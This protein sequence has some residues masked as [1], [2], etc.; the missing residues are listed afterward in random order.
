MGLNPRVLY[1]T[2][3]HLEGR[4]QV[5]GRTPIACRNWSSTTKH[6]PV[7]LTSISNVSSVRQPEGVFR[8]S[9]R[10]LCHSCA[11]AELSGS[12]AFP[13]LSGPC[14]PRRLLIVSPLVDAQGNRG[15]QRHTAVCTLLRCHGTPTCSKRSTSGPQTTDKS[16]C[17][18]P[19]FPASSGYVA[20][21]VQVSSAQLPLACSWKR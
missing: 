15:V 18:A 2:G 4:V 13:V 19:L 12:V 1:D 16:L 8:R 3:S 5:P 11:S 17:S 7:R 20:T 21:K 6:C 14:H 10:Q 9:R